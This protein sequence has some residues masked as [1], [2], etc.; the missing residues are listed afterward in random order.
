MGLFLPSL[1]I[2][3][4][5]DLTPE[6]LSEL[7]I[8]ALALDVDNTLARPRIKTPFPDVD[9][10]I[11]LMKKNRINLFIVSNAMPKRVAPIAKRFSLPFIPIAGKPFPFGLFRVMKKTG[12]SRKRL[13]MVGDQVFTDIVAAKL[14]GVYS[15]LVRP[16]E[17]EPSWLYRIKRRAEA[18]VIRKYQRKHM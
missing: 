18:R 9:D 5:T 16:G 12:M 4:I 11:A 7:G 8:D 17:P 10:W 15:I 14:A 1:F 2:E 13:A 6:R 3:R